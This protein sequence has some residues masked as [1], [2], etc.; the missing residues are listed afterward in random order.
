MKWYILCGSAKIHINV[1][2]ERERERDSEETEGFIIRVI[3]ITLRL[4]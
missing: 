2:P 1:E 4:I 3:T